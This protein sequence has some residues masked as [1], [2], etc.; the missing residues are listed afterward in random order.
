MSSGYFVL[1][2]AADPASVAPALRQAVR[3]L[4]PGLAVTDVATGATLVA[5]SLRRRAT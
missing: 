1:R 3:E 5:D 2:T 4:D